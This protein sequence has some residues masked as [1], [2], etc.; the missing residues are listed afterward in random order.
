MLRGDKDVVCV[1]ILEN[2]T[3]CSVVHET[4]FVK[5]EGQ[6]NQNDCHMN[7]L[8]LGEYQMK[9]LQVDHLLERVV[10]PVCNFLNCVVV[11]PRQA[12][13]EIAKV[14]R[15]KVIDIEE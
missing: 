5:L 10:K 4:K 7:L 3:V 13:S 8:V 6:V 15:D 2:G 9:A 12:D 11:P 1:N 14:H